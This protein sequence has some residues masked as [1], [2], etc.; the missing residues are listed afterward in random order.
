MD[1]IA[2]QRTVDSNTQA[3]E[4]SKVGAGTERSALTSLLSTHPPWIPTCCSIMPSALYT[5]NSSGGSGPGAG[6]PEAPGVSEM[7]SKQA[8]GEAPA[9]GLGSTLCVAWAW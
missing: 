8:P 6:E 3:H 2:H 7:S 4:D 1:H 5:E 9:V